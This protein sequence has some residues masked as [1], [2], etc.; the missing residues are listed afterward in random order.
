[1]PTFP[2]QLQRAGYRT[3]FIGKWHMGDS[4]LQGQDGADDD[5][6]MPQPG[7]DHWISFCGQGSYRD[8]LLNFNG[9]RRKVAGY[10]TDILTEESIRFLRER[11]DRPFLLYLSHKA[12]HAGFDPADRHRHLYSEARV[13][14]PAT[15]ELTERNR[16]GKPEWQ[17]RKRTVSRHGLANLYG[18]KF[19]LEDLYRDY[20][21]TLMAVDESVGRVCDELKTQGVFE[22][23]LVIYMGD[24]GFLLGEHGLVDKRVMYEPSIRVPLIAHCPSLFPGGRALDQLALNLDICP[25]LLEAAGLPFP[26]TVQGRSLMPLLRG[27]S[28]AWRSEFLYEYFWDYEAMHTPTVLGLRSE[29]YSY[30]EHQGIWDLNELYD[31]A[32]DPEQTANLLGG[33]RV[34]TQAGGWFQQIRDPALKELARDLR[35]RMVRILN[36]TGG[37]ALTRGPV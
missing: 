31:V 6:D 21:R 36:E 10:I 11:R 17:I 28:T 3:A 19:T 14:V 7:F 37:Q 4:Q 30:M 18:G 1:L 20:A 9:K 13:P 22:N 15:A 35:S 23:T 27:G 25:T 2:Q 16:R 34:T 24:N 5:S 33:I 26:A 8:P 12:V 29:R 32:S